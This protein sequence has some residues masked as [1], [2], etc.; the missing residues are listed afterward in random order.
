MIFKPENATRI[1]IVDDNLDIH[2]DFKKILCPDMAAASRIADLE[3]SLFGESAAASGPKIQLD[4][5][6]QGEEAAKMTAR[7]LAENRPYSLAFVDMRMPP[8]WDGLRTMEEMKKIDPGVNFVVCSAYSDY[9]PD[10][11]CQRL[12]IRDGILF[13]RKPFDP[14]D[15]RM[16]AGRMSARVPALNRAN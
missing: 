10:Q 16:I 13:I 1:L 7:A 9:T 8:G 6:F 12:E 4:T 14:A 2:A 11:V 3:A 15:V 5:A